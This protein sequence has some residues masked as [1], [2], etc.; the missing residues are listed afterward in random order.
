MSSSFALFGLVAASALLLIPSG[1]GK[2]AAGEPSA[3]VERVTAGKLPRKALKLYTAQAGRIEAFEETPL[4]AKLPA[5]VKNVLVD[6]GDPV[7]KDQA[8]VE[9]SI[10]EMEDELEQKEALVAQAEAEVRLAKAAVGAAT[11]AVATAKSKVSQAEAGVIRAD[12]EYDRWKAESDRITELAADGSLTQK[13]ADETASQLRAAE[14]ARTEAAAAVDA[15]KAA[16]EQSERNVDKAIADQG[17]AEARVRVAKANLAHLKT[18]IGY[19]TIK[20]PYDGVVSAR[21]VDT[22]DFVQPA[23]GAGARPLIKVAQTKKVR[24]FV[25]VPEEEAALVDGGEKGDPASVE[26]QALGGR[27]FDANV[28]RT[29]WTL[30]STNHALRAEIDIDNPQGA[31]RPG[32]YAEVTILLDQRSDA[33]VLPVAALVREGRETYCFCVE[34]GKSQRRRIEVGLRSGDVL[35]VVSGIGDGDTVVLDRAEYLKPGQPVEAL[36]PEKK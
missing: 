35:E 10:P 19:T 15:A 28:T 23:S 29:S 5:Y 11:A 13:K 34:S 36:A 31:L 6:I 7:V 25:E 20:A 32:M 8:L 24:I 17:A 9:L 21:L 22:G 33:L 27:Q 16:I 14:A 4:H 26:V 2:P 12:G 1:C 18:M 30:S 3:V